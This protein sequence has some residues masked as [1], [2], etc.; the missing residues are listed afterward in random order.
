MRTSVVARPGRGQTRWGTSATALQWCKAERWT[1]FLQCC[2]YK[3]LVGLC[4]TQTLP[5][6]WSHLRQSARSSVC[7]W[8]WMT[9]PG[10]GWERRGPLWLLMALPG[11]TCCCIRPGG[12][13]WWWKVARFAGGHKGR[14]SFRDQMSRQVR[15]QGLKYGREIMHSHWSNSIWQIVLISKL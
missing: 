13:W 7:W 9:P 3:L 12:S 1:C 5:G 11:S 4:R 6:H 15:C 14:H 2:Q 10:T 8:M